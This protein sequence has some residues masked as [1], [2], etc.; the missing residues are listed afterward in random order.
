M[1][2]VTVPRILLVDVVEM[3][4]PAVRNIVFRRVFN[5]KVTA[6]TF[7]EVVFRNMLRTREPSFTRSRHNAAMRSVKRAVEVMRRAQERN[8]LHYVC[9]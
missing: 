3:E 5:K 7:N 1:D 9:V 8:Q 6:F 2:D 4:I